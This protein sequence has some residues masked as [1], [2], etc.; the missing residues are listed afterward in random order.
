MNRIYSL[1]LLFVIGMVFQT[2]SAVAGNGHD[3][4]TAASQTA[5]ASNA[6]QY[7]CPM[8]PDVQS[9]KPGRCPECGMDLKQMPESETTG[10]DGHK[11]HA[12]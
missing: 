1:L 7:V 12:H 6:K 4:G 10:T 5:D 8:H 2:G 9:E 3:H 11:G